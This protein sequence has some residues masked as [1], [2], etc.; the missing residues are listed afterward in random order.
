MQDIPEQSIASIKKLFAA[1]SGAESSEFEVIPPSGS[2]RRYFRCINGDR[3]ALASWNESDE[4]NRAFA[5]MTK[6]FYAEGVPV[7]E[8][9]GEDLEAKVLLMEDFGDK[10][11]FAFLAENRDGA[12]I[13]SAVLDLYRESLERLAFMQIVAGAELDY[14]ICYPDQEFGPD[15]M[16]FDLSYFHQWFLKKSDV[17]YDEEKLEGEFDR[18]VKQLN[19]AERNYFMYR[20]FQSR[21]IMVR[22]GAIGFID[23]QG[24]RRGALQYDVI[25]LLFQAKA[26]LPDETREELLEDYLKAASKLDAFATADFKKYYN[27]FVL[28]RLLQVLGAY[29]FRGL[30]ERRPHFL[31][32]IT[33][34]LNNLRSRAEQ[35]KIPNGFPELE[36]VIQGL[37]QSEF[38]KGQ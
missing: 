10:T 32:S 4:E 24:G 3:T 1:W 27:E 16:R 6:H 34:G 35:G 5:V 14:T 19:E 30:H 33:F 18:F 11:L 2:A 13:G 25:S 12:N 29:G 31:E 23:Y 21:N 26:Q 28:L 22:N 36:K 17:N 9:Y 7:P 37:V 38:Y 15:S 8:L 20:D